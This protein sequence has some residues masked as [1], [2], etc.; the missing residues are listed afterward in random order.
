VHAPVATPNAASSPVWSLAV[1]QAGASPG[2]VREAVA[3]EG[4][5]QGTSAEP[6]T[7]AGPPKKGWWQRT[8]RSEG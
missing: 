5:E 2:T 3:K 6:A 4:P 1:D 7:P 8:F